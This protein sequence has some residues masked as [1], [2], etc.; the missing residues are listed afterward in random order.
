MT[1][2]EARRAVRE[3]RLACQTS[4]L[5]P[6]FVRTQF[7]QGLQQREGFDSFLQNAVP[8]GRWAEPDDIAPAV[9][10][11]ASKAGVFVN[12]HVLAIDGGM[13]ARM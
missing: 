12:G 9:V 11:L 4:S 6:G 1:G 3:G 13:L 8:L 5:A 2:A 10:Y 7:T